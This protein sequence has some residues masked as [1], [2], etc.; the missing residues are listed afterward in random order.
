MERLE[1]EEHVSQREIALQ[2][3]LPNAYIR[4]Y[5]LY[6]FGTLRLNRPHN[7]GNLLRI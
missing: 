4:I 5:H 3:T 1:L 7:T 6:F 2:K